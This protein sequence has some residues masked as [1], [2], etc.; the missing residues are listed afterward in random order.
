MYITGLFRKALFALSSSSPIR[1]S[2]QFFLGVGQGGPVG[3]GT[4]WAK[5]NTSCCHRRSWSWRGRRELLHGHHSVRP[6]APAGGRLLSRQS[7]D[8][9]R[10]RFWF[11]PLLSL[12]FFSSYKNAGLRSLLTELLG[13]LN[14]VPSI[15]CGTHE[16]GVSVCS[17][18]PLTATREPGFSGNLV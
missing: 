7:L 12:F 1:F 9:A 17:L 4:I 15:G 16:L 14:E 8:S 10:S 3:P 18:P 13:G 5:E 11:L 2:M 6:W